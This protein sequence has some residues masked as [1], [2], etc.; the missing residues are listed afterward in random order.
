MRPTP[1]RYRKSIDGSTNVP[2]KLLE[3]GKVRAAQG[4]A[5]GE[6][7]THRGVAVHSVASH[8]TRCGG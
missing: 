2:H 1:I 7:V 6:I 5:V 3:I 4:V 8:K